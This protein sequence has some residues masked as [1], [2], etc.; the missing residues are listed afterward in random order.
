MPAHDQSQL[1]EISTFDNWDLRFYIASTAVTA[2]PLLLYCAG[3]I[4]SFE[5]TGPT[6]VNACSQIYIQRKI[7]CGT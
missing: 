4:T 1:T 6:N 7:L 5:H 3:L 2:L